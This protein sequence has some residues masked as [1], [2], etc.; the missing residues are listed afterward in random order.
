MKLSAFKFDLPPELIALH[1][2]DDRE[3]ARLM[4]I[5][6]DT[7]KIEHKIFKDILDYFDEG[8]TLV[9]NDTKV[10]P[11]KLCGSKEKTGAPIE[12]FLLRELNEELH[13]WDA[14]VDPAR[15]IRVGNKLYFGNGELVA[16]VLD[17]TTSRGRTL[18]FLFE[19]S[20]QALFRLIDE[21]GEVPLPKSIN[22]KVELVDRTNYQTVYAKYTGAVAAPVA[23]LHFT[24]NLLKRL[25]IKGVAI[26][27]ITLH[28]GLGTL[29]SVDVEDLTKH[30]VDS[31]IFV[32]SEKTSHVVNKSLDNKKKVCAVGASSLKALESS[33]SASSRVKPIQGWTNKFIFPPYTA[34]VCNWLISNFHLPG[35]TLLMNSAAFGGYNLIM[36]AYQVAIKE[37]YR[38]SAYGDAVLIVD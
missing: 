33:V 38:F 23:G 10:F 3:E 31:E 20:T 29:R 8:D 9:T 16:E 7:G 26:A 18:K 25:E 22:R 21:L 27:P 11:A 17:N 6:K 4:V 14:L 28:I 12:V 19:G 35:S 24:K 30:K 2:P 13:L 37:Q 36:Q 1:P 32:I 5:H 34:K 15:K